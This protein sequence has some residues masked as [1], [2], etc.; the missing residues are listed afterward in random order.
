MKK[1][2]TN[3]LQRRNV[4][5]V[6]A[7]RLILAT[8]L[9]AL[10]TLA[11]PS[12]L[13]AQ[14]GGTTNGVTITQNVGDDTITVSTINIDYFSSCSWIVNGLSSNAAWGNNYLFAGQGAA[15]GVA[16]I[17]MSDFTVSGYAPWIGTSTGTSNFLTLPSGDKIFGD[18]FPGTAVNNAEAGGMGICISYTPKNG[19]PTS[20]NFVQAYV[21]NINGKGF[22]TGVIDVSSGAGNPF[23]N[24]SSPGA[25]T[26]T[27]LQGNTSPLATSGT[28]PGWIGD[29][30]YDNEFGPPGGPADDT[31]T[32]TAVYFQTFV[33]AQMNIGG[34]NYNVMYGGIQW[35]Y[36]FNTLD[37]VPEPGSVALGT[38][39]VLT[40]TF[41]R[42][43]RRL[44]RKNSTRS[45]LTGLLT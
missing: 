20:I 41:A 10:I 1:E 18:T 7:S 25:G 34:T 43:Y 42:R 5:F 37:I 11:R 45:S 40:A 3:Q 2:A 4:R 28:K 27:N 13:Y 44:R 31:V 19:D 36:T 33:E 12:N 23:Y 22:T 39:G 38:V 35:G 29:Q 30:P 6:C 8:G 26:G 17:S 16:G 14:V 15:S 24:S 21:E 9:A 32:N